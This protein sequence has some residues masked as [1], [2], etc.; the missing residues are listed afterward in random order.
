MH[1]LVRSTVAPSSQ[2]HGCT[3]FS[4][5]RL[6]LLVRSTV[7]PSSQV[8]GCTFFSSPR[9]HLLLRS[10]VA[11]S[12]QVHGCTFFSGPRLHL[13]LR[14]TVAPS[15]QVHGCTFF[16]GPRLHLLLRSTVAPSSQVHGCTFFSGPRLHLLLRSTVAPSSQVHGCTFLS[17]PRLHLLLRSTVAPSSQVHGCTFFSGPRLHLLLR[18]TVATFFSGPRLHLLLRSTVAPSSQVH[19]CTFFSAAGE[20]ETTPVLEW[21][22]GSVSSIEAL[23]N[24][25]G[26]NINP[27]EAVQEGWLCL[28]RVMRGWGISTPEDLTGWLRRHGFPGPS[29]GHHISALAQEFL[30]GQACAED[31]R[32]ALLEAVYVQLAIHRGRQMAV[33]AGP[34]QPPL[35][36]RARE[37]RRP[38][39]PQEVPVA[40]W[41]ELDD[42]NLNQL[43]LQR[44]PMLKK[45][46]HF[47]RGRLRHCFGVALRER[48]RAKRDEDPLSEGR[49]W[50]LFGLVPMMLL[51]RPRGTGSIGR[52]ELALRADHFMAGRWRSLIASAQECVLQPRKIERDQI[53]HNEQER[54][55]RAAQSRVQQGQVSRARHELTGAPLAP[56][57]DE[58][59]RGLQDRRPQEQAR[60]IPREVLEFEP[61]QP[62]RLDTRTFFDCL[63]STPAGSAPGP[64]GCS[65]EMLKVCLDDPEV[66]APVLGSRGYGKGHCI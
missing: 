53:V 27:G 41:S 25:H 10:T 9:L 51:H 3:F 63:R 12:C 1:L 37:A 47:L 4:G 36:R 39:I 64:G 7:A 28:R 44:V 15:S 16:S 23:T 26:G 57:N 33:P 14:S 19:G 52:D 55:G 50:K 8:H 38:P 66:S 60:P 42:F 45:C 48:A 17:G 34:S 62:L 21:L 40:T 6:H 24:F 22:V 61:S 43:F 20:V 49:A 32:V 54:R 2:V 13:L 29:P 35:L 59:F 18:S 5:P 56:K 30:L 65:Y 11:P 31:G 58:T 46:P